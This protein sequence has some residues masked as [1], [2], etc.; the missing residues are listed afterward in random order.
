MSAEARG[1]WGMASA[2]G[3]LRGSTGLKQRARGVDEGAAQNTLRVEFRSK[4]RQRLR[5]LL[6]AL[7]L[8]D[9]RGGGNPDRACSAGSAQRSRV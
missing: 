9:N 3:G 8:L 6:D 5:C 7:L 1:G 2:S 4:G